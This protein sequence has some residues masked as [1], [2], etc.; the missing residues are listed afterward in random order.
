MEGEAVFDLLS[1]ECCLLKH[2][3]RGVQRLK[4]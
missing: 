4:L 2:L 3:D 1:S